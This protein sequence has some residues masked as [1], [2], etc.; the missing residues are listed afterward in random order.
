M[1]ALRTRVMMIDDCIRCGGSYLIPSCTPNRK[2]IVEDR[3]E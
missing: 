3:E 2:S 1:V